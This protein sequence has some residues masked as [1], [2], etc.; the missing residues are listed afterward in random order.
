MIALSLEEELRGLLRVGVVAASP[1]EIGPASPDLLEEME[2]LG[3]RLAEKWTGR[4]PAEI[5]VLKPARELYKSFGI[6]PTKTRPSSE[7]L[8][9]RLLRAKPLPRIMN[10][11]DLC[12]LLSLSFM[13]PLGLYNSAKIDGEVTLRRGRADE[14]YPGIR[15]EAVHLDG[16]PLLSDR[17]GAFGNPT[18]DSLR[19][20]VDGATGA[21][22]MVIFAPRS[23]SR[24]TM[25]ANVQE[26]GEGMRRHLSPDG[27]PAAWD[28][29]VM[30]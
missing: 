16:R 17:Q 29:S 28:G 25:E 10:A 7:A 27:E 13:L 23:V 24:E 2:R 6:D 5:D 8:L 19:T 14:S 20:S 26:A 4:S 11:V 12:N 1:V 21:L 18:S 30:D 9:R 15:K 22:W 3:S